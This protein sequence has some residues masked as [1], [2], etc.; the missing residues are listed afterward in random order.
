MT[1]SLL[2]S[3]FEPLGALIRLQ[4]D[5]ERVFDRPLGWFTTATAGR[6][7]F[8][9]ANVFRRNDH[10]VVRFE[11]P[12]VAPEDLTVETQMDSIRVS[13]KRNAE[14]AVGFAH[15]EE[16]WSGEFSRTLQLPSDADVS[17]A[18]AQYKRGALSLEVPLRE[19]AKPRRIALQP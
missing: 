11:V 4:E 1:R 15:R 12:G 7:A 16:R 8:P 19:D 10:Y 17:K 9:P 18:S 6:G 3:E 2:L 13:G 5:L 14:S